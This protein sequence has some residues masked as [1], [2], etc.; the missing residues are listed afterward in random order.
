MTREHALLLPLQTHAPKSVEHRRKL[1]EAVPKALTEEQRQQARELRSRGWTFAR[2]AGGMGVSE[3][4]VART[5]GRT[6]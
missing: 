2:I 3:S 1:S 4:T 6:Y 5:C